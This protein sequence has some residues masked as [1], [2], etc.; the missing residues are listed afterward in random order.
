MVRSIKSAAIRL[1]LLLPLAA[2]V[3]CGQGLQ[4]YSSNIG[5]SSQ[6]LSYD[7]LT[8]MA[9]SSVPG[10]NYD[11][12][13]MSQFSISF[14]AVPSQDAADIVIGLS[15]DVPSE[16]WKLAAIVRFNIA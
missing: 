4:S 1:L 8:Y 10:W 13:T 7:G 15:Q 9:L 2:A 16:Y 5:E 12:L 11:P 6:A 3:G 14:S